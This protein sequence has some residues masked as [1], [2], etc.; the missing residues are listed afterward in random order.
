MKEKGSKRGH[1]ERLWKVSEIA[2]DFTLW[3]VWEIPIKANNTTHE[4]FKSFHAVIVETF[5]K[6]QANRSLAGLLFTVRY[7]LGKVLPLDKNINT[8]SIPGCRETSIKSRLTE[9]D[10]AV[11]KAGKAI[12]FH[13][14]DL[15][16]CPVYLYENESLH[17]LSNDTVHALIHFG[18]IK[19]KDNGYTATMAIYVKP[20]GVYGRVY[21]KLIEP[22]RHHIVYPTMMKMIKKQWEKHILQAISK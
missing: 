22:F 1:P 13:N 14:S 12:K 4:N 21:L 17:E 9:Q 18:W 19:K 8:L 7:W 3:D 5:T 16:F 11:S 10:N 20:R 15:E 6:M 2:N